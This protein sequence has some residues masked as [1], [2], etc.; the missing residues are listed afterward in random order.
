MSLRNC[1]ES[2]VNHLSSRL[3]S[4]ETLT[5]HELILA[6]VGIFK[7]PVSKLSQTMI[8]SRYRQ[9]LGSP[10][11]QRRPCQ[12]PTHQGSSKVIKN[13]DVVNLKMAKE[14]LKFHGM[15][16]PTGSGESVTQFSSL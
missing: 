8:C 10:E 5:E 16:V 9:K 14:I 13:R 4:R 1:N 6:R 15:I 3:L 2:I 7:L 12:Y 11:I